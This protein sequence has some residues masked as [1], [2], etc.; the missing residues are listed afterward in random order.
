[1]NFFS[2]FNSQKVLRDFLLIVLAEIGNIAL[3][4]LFMPFR[5]PLFLDTIFT[6]A[7]TFYAGLVPGLIVA[8]LYNPILNF[9]QYIFL[10]IDITLFASFYAIPGMLIAFTTWIFS[11]NKTEFL[12][13]KKITFL[14]LL[15]IVFASSFASCF[16]AAAV[17]VFLRPALSFQQFI[18]TDENLKWDLLSWTFSKFGFCSY[19][20]AL[21]PRIPI[22][23][24]DRTICTFLGFSI[25]RLLEKID[26]LGY[27]EI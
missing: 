14:Y 2:A 19:L 6:V 18:F 22:T 1:M 10:K 26:P 13:S 9:T 15:L 27:K 11:R 25:Y 5:L 17:D 8:A 7:I 3:A 24:L 21:L 16:S 23:L 4:F 20:S 12:F